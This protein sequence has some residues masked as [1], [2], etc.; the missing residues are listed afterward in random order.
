MIIVL[1]AG[2]RWSKAMLFDIVIT[3]IKASVGVIIGM[4]IHSILVGK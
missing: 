1:I 2:R 3:L 4:Y